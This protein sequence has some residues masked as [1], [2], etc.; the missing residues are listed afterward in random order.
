MSING[1][2][3]NTKMTLSSLLLMFLENIY[4]HI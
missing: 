2:K 1:T 3:I 4:I